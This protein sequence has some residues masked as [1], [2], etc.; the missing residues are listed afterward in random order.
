MT[1]LSGILALAGVLAAAGAPPA[2]PR[3]GRPAPVILYTDA[4]TAP[5]SGGE[6]GQGGYLSIFGRNLGDR[7]GIGTKT[8]VFIGTAEVA[9]YRYL[10][11]SV[12]FGKQHIEQLTVQVGALGKMRPGTAAP[13]KVVV[14]GVASNTDQT[15]TPSGG[16]VLFVALTGNDANAAPNE[17]KR[18][19]RHLQ[20]EASGKGAYYAMRA[21][22]QIVIRG[23]KYSDADGIDGTWMRFGKD[24]TKK[25]TATGWIHVTAHP[26]PVN[27]NAIETVS[28][29]APGDKPGGIQGP[30]S[31]IRGVSGSYIA[32]SNLHMAASPTTKGDGAPINLQYSDGPWRI[33]N[34]ELGPWPSTLSAPGNAKAGGIA[35]AGNPVGIY[36]N[37]I[38]DID[39]ASGHAISPLENHGIYIE[40]DGAYDI[41]WNAIFA[42]R[43]GN[44]IQTYNNGSG[45][46]PVTNNVSIHHNMFYGSIGKHGVN[47]ADG[48]GA[49]FKVFDNVIT[50]ATGAGIRMNSTEL[51]GAKIWNNTIFNVNRSRNAKLGAIANDAN[52]KPGFVDVSNNIIWPFPGTLYAGG[53]AGFGGAESTWANNLFFGGL[54]PSDAGATTWGK[55]AVLEN[56]K[57]VGQGFDFR[58]SPGSPAKDR[59]TPAVSGVVTNDFAGTPRPQGAGFDIGAYE[60]P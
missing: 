60:L 47:I 58:L 15:F 12:V 20:D 36:G 21:G 29:L 49:G 59:G 51:R 37:Y 27:G 44:G 19:W 26:G 41:G 40:N 33:V 14:N 38:H 39:C 7:A 25:G 46:S 32:V 53:S 54:D 30:W 9:N 48:S 10:G 1:P 42:I 18:P 50:D 35:G 55:Q 8:K 24:A 4:A 17:I 22:D 3:P 34:N 2:P 6:N 5:T 11:P 23:G 43:G 56:P 45:F 31:N 16:R 57:F 52:G 13:V 28:Y